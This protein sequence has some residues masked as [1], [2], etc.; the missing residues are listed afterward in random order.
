MEQQSIST[1]YNLL[2]KWFLLNLELN[3]HNFHSVEKLLSS[4]FPNQNMSELESIS[5]DAV[6]SSQKKSSIDSKD[7]SICG[8]KAAD[9]EPE[10][11]FKRCISCSVLY[12]K[13]FSEY[14]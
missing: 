5:S 7:N 1:T 2:F 12:P 6:Y 13:G 14:T 3:E 8:T 10:I 9:N 4:L 11:T